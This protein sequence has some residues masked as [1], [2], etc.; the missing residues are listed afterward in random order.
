MELRLT[1]QT[2]PWNIQSIM[3]W[4]IIPSSEFDRR[5]SGSGVP[6][7]GKV[8]K[9]NPQRGLVHLIPHSADDSRQKGYSYD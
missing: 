1:H 3:L 5:V 8:V 2:A 4:G 9:Y 6:A 7:A